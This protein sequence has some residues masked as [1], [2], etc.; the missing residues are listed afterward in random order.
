MA[1]DYKKE[2]IKEIT[3]MSGKYSIDS[4]FTD[5][6]ECCAITIQNSCCIIRDELWQERENRYLKI[7]NTYSKEEQQS[8]AK[9]LAF[10]ALA[11]EEGFSDVLGEIYMELGR[12]NKYM[13]QFFTPYHVSKLMAEM[14]FLPDEISEDEPLTLNEPTVGAGGMVIAAA[15][16]LNQRGINYQRC[17]EVTAQ[18]IDWR[19]VYMAYI[20][21]S[22]LGISATVVQG[23]TLSEPYIPGVTDERHILRTPKK[24]GILM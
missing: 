1:G 12:G 2:I 9:M 7:I 6:I 3:R 21:L 13:G 22:L 20:Q 17:M 8:F 4:V 10:L 23:N 24:M 5:W 11:Y 18:D 19:A 16:V 15:D 14:V